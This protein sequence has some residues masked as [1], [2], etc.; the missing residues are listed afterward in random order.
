MKDIANHLAAYRQKRALSAAD[1]ARAAAVSRQTIYAIES[2][3]YVPNTAVALRLARTLEVTVEALFALPQDA[4]PTE[5]VTLLPRADGQHAGDPMQLC[6]VD[7][8]VVASSPSP[9]PWYLPTADA[10][11]IDNPGRA[12]KA[13]VQLFDG[14]YD[15]S[16][17][18]LV[19]G[20]D[21][22]I[23][24]LARHVLRA[25]VEL[26]V[27]QRNSSQAL[28]LLK[29]GVIHVA[30]THLRDEA[31]GESNLPAIRRLF[32]R[33]SVAVISLA[34]WEEGIVVRPGNPK[35]VRAVADF[36]RRDVSIVNREAGAGSRALLDAHLAQLGISHEKVRGYGRVAAGHLPAA[37]QVRAGDADCCIATRAAARV[38]GL[39]FIPLV[40]ERYD[41]AI[42][43][44]HLDY[45]PVQTLLDTLNRAG[46]RRELEGLGGYDTTAA[47]RRIL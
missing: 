31:S 41:L 14:D 3:S 6:R 18:I 34:V 2:G 43:R 46:F 39:D 26:V 19:A 10:V 16:N 20:C 30:G 24:V 23:S 17:R 38:F 21:P 25:G 1:L 8:H 35:S 11:L 15:L 36:A 33:A 4:L 27:A 22:G 44:R 7:R 42:H 45:P 29:Q 12:S 5:K 28:A 9:V 47:G 32:A 13:T 40:T 37:W